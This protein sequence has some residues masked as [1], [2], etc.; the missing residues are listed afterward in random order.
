[1]PRRFA[2]L[3]AFKEAKGHCDV[4][5]SYKANPQLAR[6]VEPWL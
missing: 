6:C 5:Q 4:P 2:S 1:M 3:E